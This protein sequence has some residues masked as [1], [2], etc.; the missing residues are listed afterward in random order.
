MYQEPT[1]DNKT[2]TTATSQSEG[3]M[4]ESYL[5]KKKKRKAIM[6]GMGGCKKKKY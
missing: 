1:H 5:T 3:R 2:R 4:K 6:D